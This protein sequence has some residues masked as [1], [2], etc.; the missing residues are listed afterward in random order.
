MDLPT[1]L[2]RREKLIFFLTDLLARSNVHTE[3]L[4]QILD[5]EPGQKSQVLAATIEATRSE[6]NAIQLELM[7][8]MLD[9][10]NNQ[11]QETN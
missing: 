1:K 7:A 11:L 10:E 2:E 8:E 5:L 6:L 4:L 3:I 9:P